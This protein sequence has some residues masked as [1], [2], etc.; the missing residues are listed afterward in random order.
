MKKKFVFAIVGFFVFL[1]CFIAG[2]KIYDYF[3]KQ[4][5][6]TNLQII[7]LEMTE[8]EVVSILGKPTHIWSSD[9]PSKYWCY[10]TDTISHAL[11]EQ[12]DIECGNMALQISYMKNG[13]WLKEG[14]V[15][16]VFDFN[17]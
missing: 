16:K 10:D 13:I 6:K 9:E 5:L 2:V 12:P 14:R 8:K 1:A 17:H 3:Y 4:K 15:I 7:Q 11:E